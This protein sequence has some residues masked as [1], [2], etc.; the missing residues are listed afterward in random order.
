MRVKIGD[1]ECE[2]MFHYATRVRGGRKVFGKTSLDQR[3]RVETWCFLSTIDNTKSGKDRFHQIGKGCALRS[4]EDQFDKG[5]GRRI[6]F[7]KALADAQI[8]E[9]QRI[10]FWA[11][12]FRRHSDR[13]PEKHKV[14]LLTRAAGYLRA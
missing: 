2:V 9:A 6:A 7:A 3:R 13:I 14:A 4:L 10:Q 12:Y 11:E 1:L 8:A 5:K